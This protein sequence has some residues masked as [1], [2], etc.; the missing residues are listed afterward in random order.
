VARVDAAATAAATAP[1]PSAAAACTNAAYAPAPDANT[2]AGTA[3][4]DDTACTIAP[5]TERSTLALLENDGDTDSETNAPPAVW[6]RAVQ[7]TRPLAVVAD[8]MTGIP[9]APADT[10]A[11]AA[12]ARASA[13]ATVA[14]ANAPPSP[15]DT[16]A[17][18]RNAADTL[19]YTTAVA[20]S[21]FAEGPAEL[22]ADAADDCDAAAGDEAPAAAVGDDETGAERDADAGPAPGVDE[23]LFA[24]DGA[25][26]CEME[27]AAAPGETVAFAAPVAPGETVAFAVAF[28]APV[29]PGVVV[30]DK[31]PPVADDDSAPVGVC[32]VDASAGAAVEVEDAVGTLDGVTLG[33]D[34]LESDAVGVPVPVGV[35]VGVPVS[36]A[37]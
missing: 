3:I 21:A 19:W 1:R 30:M 36:V 6:P 34:P 5:A 2:L 37:V 7:T 12:H 35:S 22:V 15:R 28:A 24:A 33:D 14:S 8:D 17:L 9:I 26:V 23:L 32:D 13:L 18:V 10:A 4:V 29:A 16:V 11:A 20:V 27:A 25:G 31:P